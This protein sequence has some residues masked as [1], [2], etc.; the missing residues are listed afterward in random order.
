M[1]AVVVLSIFELAIGMVEKLT[2][3]IEQLVSKGAI[4]PDQQW[5]LRSR[6]ENIRNGHAFSGPEWT[7]TQTELSEEFQ[8]NN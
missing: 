6:I 3:I 2:P 7:P 1:E 4:T 8:N 5:E